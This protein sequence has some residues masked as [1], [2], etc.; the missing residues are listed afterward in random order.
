MI[1][2]SLI[3]VLLLF[4][5]S[6]VSAQDV[7]YYKLTRKMENGKS[8]TNVSGGQFITFTGNLCFESD[9][10]GVGVNHGTMKLNVA[11]SN[12][13]Y[14]LYQGSSYW[15]KNA[16]FKFNADKSVLNVVLEN[17]DVYVYKRGTAPAGQTTCSLVRKP[18]SSSSNNGGSVV[19]PPP[20]V[21]QGWG[22]YD[23]VGGRDSYNGGS[24]NNGN[25]TT[26]QQHKCGLCNGTGEVINNDGIS[27]GNTK[28]C[29]KC[30]K[31]VP[32]SHYHT[33]CPSC[34]GK[35]WW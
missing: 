9:Y 22:G 29:N 26:P 25:V 32:D 30:G 10:H 2:H 1:K 28:Y 20:S 34:K 7:R 21:Y 3:L 35:G 8:S 5:F 17:G 16:D 12:S 14:S 27:F 33:T 6:M 18:S 31:T 15:G 4:G 13:Q 24:S 19:V 11:Y 23:N